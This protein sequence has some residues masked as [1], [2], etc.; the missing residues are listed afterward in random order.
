MPYSYAAH[1][2]MPAEIR[3]RRSALVD[4]YGAGAS[5]AFAAG[6]GEQHRDVDVLMLYPLDL[7]AVEERFGSWMTQYG[8]AN[9]VTQAKLLERGKVNGGAIEMAGR[10]FT[11][12]RAVRAVPLAEAARLMTG[13]AAKGGR[14]HLVRAAAD[15]HHGRRAGAARR[16][17]SFS[18]SLTRPTAAGGIPVPGMVVQF[19]NR[20][21]AVA[22]QTIL[23][24]LLV[25]RIYPVAPREG[26][27]AGRP[28]E[29]VD[30]RRSAR[31]RASTS[32]SVRATISRKAW[33]TTFARCSTS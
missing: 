3:R 13:F 27:D 25:D 6:P 14:R 29:E 9:Y 2:G 24:D 16:G 30:R 28:R 12:L 22:P 31:N 19:E 18:A 21:A 33:A 5:P 20:L 7:V 10:R 32:A 1:W 26:L 8:Y 4:A 23:T 11:T 17:R 15:P